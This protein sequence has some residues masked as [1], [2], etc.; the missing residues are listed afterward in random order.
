MNDYIRP[1][2]SPNQV[3]K[4]IS[5]SNSNIRH[6]ASLRDNA[7]PLDIQEVL[8]DKELISEIKIQSKFFTPTRESCP[9]FRDLYY[10]FMK[11]ELPTKFIFKLVIMLHKTLLT[12]FSSPFQI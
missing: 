5:V 9:N 12:P 7:K 11:T 10:S 3:N 8:F 6:N 2:N 1:N 4:Q